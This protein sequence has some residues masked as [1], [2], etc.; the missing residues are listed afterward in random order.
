M[1]SAAI[2][3]GGI[4]L[5]DRVR[6]SSR[7]VF[8]NIHDRNAAID[9]MGD[10]LFCPAHQVVHGPVF[11]VLPDHARAQKG[12]SIDDDARFVG[13]VQ[14]RIDILNRGPGS[15]IRTN[16]QTALRNFG[17]KRQTIVVGAR[18][19]TGQPDVEHLDSKIFHEVHD[20]DL[21][22]NGRIGNSWRLQT[23]TQRFIVEQNPPLREG[24]RFADQIPV[25]NQL[26]SI[27]HSVPPYPS[28]HY[29][30]FAKAYGLSST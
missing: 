3:G 7:G 21:V 4:Q 9:G 6:K 25:I 22:V 17:C 1:P 23:V 20:L 2:D 28:F 19:S 15:A 14:D 26:L 13:N 5:L 30:P 11:D 16:F 12:C 8:G 18:A 29:L 10:G 24:T 27:Q